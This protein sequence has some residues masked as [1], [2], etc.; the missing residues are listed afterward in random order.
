MRNAGSNAIERFVM[1]KPFP[2]LARLLETLKTGGRDSTGVVTGFVSPSIRTNYAYTERNDVQV[3]V[4][5]HYAEIEPTRKVVS[6]TSNAATPT[7]GVLYRVGL[8]VQGTDPLSP[9]PFAPAT[10]SM[11]WEY[12]AGPGDAW[13]DVAN[14]IAGQINADAVWSERVTAF[15]N[16][17]TVS[18]LWLRI[19]GSVTSPDS[20][21]FF[22]A[23]A[24][25]DGAA[26]VTWA[27]AV[28]VRPTKA[29][30]GVKLIASTLLEADP[31]MRAS[32][33]LAGLEAQ[34]LAAESLTIRY[35]GLEAVD[36]DGAIQQVTWTTDVQGGCDTVASRNCEHHLYVPP[37]PARRRLEGA[38]GMW[39]R[40]GGNLGESLTN[41]Y[42]ADWPSNPYTGGVVNPY[43]A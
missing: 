36:L 31:L 22:E 7:N 13:D 39:R 37:Y 33:Y 6:V 12:L 17:G 15:S 21:L 34:Y 9:P 8:G 2:N 27:D 19:V 35:N 40:S 14:S 23:D 43:T 30:S 5:G 29:G 38:I 26:S 25:A 11:S 24:D 18:G 3:G 20:V 28:T 42:V 4:I 32:Y 1:E 41:P 10:N 16:D